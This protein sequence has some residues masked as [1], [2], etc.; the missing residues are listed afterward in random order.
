M[1]RQRCGHVL[2]SAG[3]QQARS[4]GRAPA[5]ISTPLPQVVHCRRILKWT[6]ATA[7]YTFEARGDAGLP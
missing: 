1:L 4:A 6:Y 2:R 7:Y 5:S 3:A